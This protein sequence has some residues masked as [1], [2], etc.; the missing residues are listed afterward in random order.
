MSSGSI[1]SSTSIVESAVIQAPLAKV[2]HLIKLKDLASWWNL[3]SNVEEVKDSSNEADVYKVTYKDKSTVVIKQEEH[4]AIH[5][6][7]TYSA[8]SAEPAL[9]YSSV[10]STIRVYPITS[11][12]MENSTF[13]EWSAT[14]SSDAD[15]GVIQ[16]ARYK[17][18]EGLAD[19]ARAVGAK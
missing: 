19:L 1:P 12:P 11:G 7:I 10:Y 2:W 8:V 18:K 14:F 4:S 6:Y 9:T 13:V 16:D 5:H 15:S 3:V 17:R